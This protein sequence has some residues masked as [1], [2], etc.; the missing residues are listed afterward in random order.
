[1]PEV[2]T[3]DFIITFAAVIG[4]T[5]GL[6]VFDTALAELD[7]RETRSQAVQ[8]F[9]AGQWEIGKGNLAKGI[10]HLRKATALDRKNVDY[11]IALADAVQRAGKPGEAEDL[12]TPVLDRQAN[13]GAA[14]LALA[15]VS[16]AQRKYV[17]AKSYYHRAIFGLWA[18]GSVVNRERARFELID[19][20]E[21]TGP[22]SE[23][24]AELLPIQIDSAT[25]DSLRR[26]IGMLFVTAGSPARA[27]D[28]FRE[29][30]QE[31]PRDG[32]AYAG[33]GE[34]ALAQGNFRTA[35]RDFMEARRLLEQDTAF[36][37]RIAV[38]DSALSIDPT[39]RGLGSREENRRAAN[40][41]G[42]IAAR[43]QACTGAAPSPAVQGATDSATTSSRAPKPRDLDASTTEYLSRAETLWKARPVT[44]ASRGDREDEVLN[45]VVERVAR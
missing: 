14:N 8:E 28:I 38:A 44:C 24:L 25:S 36:A 4:I 39:Q 42:M 34:A 17:D 19:L 29:L 32:I 31:N 22:K 45:L 6:F 27:A 5:L 9:S 10:E 33:M 41:L 37:E 35:E 15:R 7:A 12:L 20:L 21:K 2:K 3:H 18:P 1:M 26:R 13:S 23:L 43:I 11:T 16:V 30:I 40:L